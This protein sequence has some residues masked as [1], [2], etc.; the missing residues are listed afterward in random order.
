[1]VFTIQQTP[2]EGNDEEQVL[3]NSTRPGVVQP[4]ETTSSDERN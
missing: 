1:M 3:E 4:I 2:E